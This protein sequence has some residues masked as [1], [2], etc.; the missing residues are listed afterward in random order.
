MTY[1]RTL[2]RMLA[3][4]TGIFGITTGRAKGQETNVRKL[5]KLFIFSI[6]VAI[7][8][9][10]PFMGNAVLA[11]EQ[12]VVNT[13]HGTVTFFDQG[14]PVAPTQKDLQMIA[15]QSGVGVVNSQ[16]VECWEYDHRV[17]AT[18]YWVQ[19]GLHWC[20]DSSQ[21]FGHSV[22]EWTLF[23][24]KGYL[25]EYVSSSSSSG[26]VSQGVSIASAVAQWHFRSSGPGIDA[27]YY[28]WIEIDAT[29]RGSVAVTVHT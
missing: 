27:N 13:E 29:N 23:D 26:P 16:Y 19:L 20:W 24:V 1:A 21:T 9:P 8:A 11:S 6:I 5:Q 7:L 22:W 25:T 17:D 18:Q 15:D 12:E 28:P 3:L 4:V 14:T 2:V 10:T